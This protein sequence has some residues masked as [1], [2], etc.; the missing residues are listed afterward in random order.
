MSAK[1]TAV[2]REMLTAAMRAMLNDFFVFKYFLTQGLAI[3]YGHQVAHP[4][5]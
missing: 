1:L 4:V 5:A 2:L 3:A